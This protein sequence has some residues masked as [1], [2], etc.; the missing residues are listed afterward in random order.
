MAW[1]YQAQH[2][3]GVR[4]LRQRRHSL[5]RGPTVSLRPSYAMSGT[6]CAYAATI[7]YAMSGTDRAYAA[8]RSYAMS[9]TD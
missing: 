4:W 6:C 2:Y 5:H 1:S 9:G 8:S 3:Y 7:A